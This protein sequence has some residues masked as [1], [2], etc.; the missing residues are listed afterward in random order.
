M[1]YISHGY[2][3]GVFD[4]YTTQ[5]CGQRKFISDKLPMTEDEGSIFIKYT[6]VAVVHIIHT[7]ETSS[8]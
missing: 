8:Y 3:V 5:A 1:K 7:M 6:I 2:Y 4:I